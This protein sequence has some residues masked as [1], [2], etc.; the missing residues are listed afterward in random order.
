[1]ITYTYCKSLNH[2]IEEC[3][4]LLA[5]IQEKQHNRNVQFIGLEQWMPDPTVNVV[6]HSGTVTQPTKPS[7]A[8]V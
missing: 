3:L 6:T 5:K 7:G 8:W 4:I 2:A 1:M